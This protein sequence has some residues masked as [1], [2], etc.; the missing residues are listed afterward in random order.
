M[1]IGQFW[2]IPISVSRTHMTQNLINQNI[3]VL[4][5]NHPNTNKRLVPAWLVPVTWKPGHTSCLYAGDSEGGRIS[6]IKHPKDSLIEG[7]Y[8]NYVVSNL[9]AT[10]FLYNQF[11]T[12][13]CI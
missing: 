6:E 4:E 12:T 13:L 2:N 9:F 5:I 11:D 8:H 1:F 7:S 3:R 10:D